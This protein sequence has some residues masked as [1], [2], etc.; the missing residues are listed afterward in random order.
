MSIATHSEIWTLEC[1]E[2]ILSLEHLSK[3]LQSLESGRSSSPARVKIHACVIL[4]KWLDLFLLTSHFQLHSISWLCL[5]RTMSKAI[6]L[7]SIAIMNVMRS[8]TPIFYQTFFKSW[9]FSLHELESFLDFDFV[10]YWFYSCYSVGRKSKSE[11]L[12]LCNEWKSWIF[13]RHCHTV[14]NLHILWQIN[15][16]K[17]EENLFL[18]RWRLSKKQ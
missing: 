17:L 12:F 8:H 4:L 13:F 16:R 11:L 3:I 5:C 9:V 6:L 10:K 18:A 7:F 14:V 2:N 15:V 1:S